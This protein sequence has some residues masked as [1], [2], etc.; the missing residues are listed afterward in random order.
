VQ[1]LTAFELIIPNQSIVVAASSVE[2]KEK[3]VQE[4]KIWIDRRLEE[5]GID[6]YDVRILRLIFLMLGYMKVNG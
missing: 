2:E 3:W 6:D 5:L 4:I 1:R